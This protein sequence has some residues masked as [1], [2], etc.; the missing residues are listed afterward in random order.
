[1]FFGDLSFFTGFTEKA[2]IDSGTSLLVIP[3]DDFAWL[4]EAIL[5]VD[6]QLVEDQEN[7]IF[8]YEYPCSDVWEI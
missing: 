2:I 6:D 3:N 7:G 1:M 5:E 4:F 8:L